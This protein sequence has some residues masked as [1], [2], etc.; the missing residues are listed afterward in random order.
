MSDKYFEA[1]VED[2]IS[3]NY[4]RQVSKYDSLPMV[5]GDHKLEHIDTSIVSKKFYNNFNFSKLALRN[6]DERI[7][8][9]VTS[10]NNKEGK[11]LAATNMAV[12]L[13]RAYHQLTV[14]VDLNINNPQLHNI[15]GAQEQP[16][17]AEAMKD[18]VLHV[19][20]TGI[21]DLF[22]LP[23]GDLSGYHPGIEDTIALR[24]IISTLK[25]EFDFIIFDMGSV[26]PVEDFPIHFI[27]EID[28][29]L[30]VI[31]AKKTKRDQLKKIYKHIDERRVI[32]YIF[33]RFNH[34]S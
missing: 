2:I 7:A 21:E 27:N 1:E 18:G 23:A 14:L 29:L 15:F 31:D 10:P 30:A 22:L 5:I 6:R 25:Q 11:T 32:G 16:G 8:I 28:G 17:L 3:S 33:N 34:K 13:T 9:G 19:T 4:L 24:S 12:S 20:P 26:F